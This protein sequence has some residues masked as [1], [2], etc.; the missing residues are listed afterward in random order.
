MNLKLIADIA[1]QAEGLDHPELCVLSKQIA[2]LKAK[3]K[4]EAEEEEE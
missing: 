2:A 4:A 1:I 3:A